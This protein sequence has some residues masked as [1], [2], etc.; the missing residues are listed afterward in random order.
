MYLMIFELLGLRLEVNDLDYLDY[1]LMKIYIFYLRLEIFSATLH[2]I[3][4]DNS[5]FN[6]S[7]VMHPN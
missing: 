1:L 7:P 2:P 6:P 5:S 4:A 3:P